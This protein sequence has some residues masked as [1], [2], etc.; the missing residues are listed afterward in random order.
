MSEALGAAGVRDTLIA[1][2]LRGQIAEDPAL[3]EMIGLLR[4]CDLVSVNELIETGV[5]ASGKT[6]SDVRRLVRALN[7]IGVVY[8]SMTGCTH[9]GLTELGRRWLAAGG[10]VEDTFTEQA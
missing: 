10:L 1:A 2:V 9:V 6:R 3:T 4:M 5:K 7:R 8:H